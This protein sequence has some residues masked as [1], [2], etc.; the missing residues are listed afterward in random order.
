[1]DMR[2]HESGYVLLYDASVGQWLEFSRPA[3]IVSVFNAA[4]V[5]PAIELIEKIVSKG[6]WAAGFVAY[7]AAPGF[8]DALQVHAAQHGLPLL[9]FGL[10]REPRAVMLPQA[11]WKGM[12]WQPDI[13]ETEYAA[14][15]RRI[16]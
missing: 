4:D 14:A 12:Q 8:D 7:E 6:Y 11:A 5:V 2:P 1:M 16:R 9:Y 13:S 10:Y 15:L 3:E